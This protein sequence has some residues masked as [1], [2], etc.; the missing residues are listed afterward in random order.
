MQYIELLTDA[1]DVYAIN[2]A[3]CIFKASIHQLSKLFHDKEHIHPMHSTPFIWRWF[4]FQIP[5]CQQGRAYSYQK[6][7][8]HRRAIFQ[9]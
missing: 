2:E 5:A 1:Q 4:Y 6:G 8:R 7:D 9:M 3:L